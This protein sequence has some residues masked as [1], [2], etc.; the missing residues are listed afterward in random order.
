MVE[1]RNVPRDLFYSKADSKPAT[2]IDEQENEK[3]AL[4]VSNFLTGERCFVAG[5]SNRYWVSSHA[6]HNEIWKANKQEHG[7]VAQ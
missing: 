3:S 1:V 5:P 2:K 6:S 7:I 4:T